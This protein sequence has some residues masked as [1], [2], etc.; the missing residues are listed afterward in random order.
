MEKKTRVFQYDIKANHPVFNINGKLFV[1]DYPDTASMARLLAFCLDQCGMSTEAWKELRKT[2]NYLPFWENPCHW[3]RD[4]VEWERTPFF[5]RHIRSDGTACLVASDGI[6]PGSPSMGR[7]P[8]NSMVLQL[9]QDDSETVLY[10]GSAPF[11]VRPCLIPLAEDGTVDC[12]GFAAEHVNGQI[13]RGGTLYVDGMP[14]NMCVL[15]PHSDYCIDES[16]APEWELFWI[17]WE[18]KLLASKN[19]WR[20]YPSHVQKVMGKILT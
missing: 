19:L 4:I 15:Q 2:Q 9:N 5:A 14:S 6:S 16:Y 7:F 12:E 20:V 11:Y 10:S 3:A 13:I 18:G 8:K 1:L 17:C